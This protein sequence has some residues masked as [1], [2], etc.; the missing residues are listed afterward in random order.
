MREILNGRLPSRWREPFEDS[1]GRSFARVNAFAGPSVE[2]HLTGAGAL[3]LAVDARTILLSTRLMEMPLIARLAI[4]GHELAHTVQFTREGRDARGA[5]EA[6]AWRGAWA[7]LRG[8]K[9]EILCGARQERALPAVAFVMDKNGED[10]FKIFDTLDPLL[11][12]KTEMIKPLT[13]EKLLDLFL[14]KKFETEKDF[15]IQ[16]HGT[17]KGFAFPIATVQGKGAGSTAQTH[18]LLQLVTLDALITAFN[19]AGDDLAKLNGVLKNVMKVDAAPDA[20]AAKLTIKREI[21]RQKGVVGLTGDADIARVV[22]KMSDVRQKKRGTIELRTCNMGVLTNTLNFF[23]T[24]FNAES[25]GAPDKY[26]AFGTCVPSIGPNAMKDFRKNNPD[27]KLFTAVED[28]F[29]FTFSNITDQWTVTTT[30]A[31]INIAAVKSFVTGFIMGGKKFQANNFPIH[32][33]LSHPA[34]FPLDPAYKSSIKR[35]KRP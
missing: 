18:L 25:L 10:Y 22:K 17:P 32:F 28:Q 4:V 2:G 33:L 30:G 26:S 27:A 16:A 6:E 3:A 5:L 31:A 15:V 23:R 24:E 20:A 9:C 29:G 8:E 12:T 21:D 11:V 19:A 35:V 1:F 34:I 14:D 13:Y 7:A